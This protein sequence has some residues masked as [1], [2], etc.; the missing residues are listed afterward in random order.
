MRKVKAFIGLLIL[1]SVVYTI[2]TSSA[3][4]VALAGPSFES[5]W[6][7][8]VPENATFLNTTNPDTFINSDPTDERY[9][10]EG[11][12][13]FNVLVFADEEARPQNHWVGLKF[14]G[15]RD[16]IPVYKNWKQYALWQIERAD[17]TL[18]AE[19][20]IDIRVIDFIDTWDSKDSYEYMDNLVYELWWEQGHYL[21]GEYDGTMIDAIIGITAQ[22]TPGDEW[23]PGRKVYGVTIPSGT[24]VLKWEAYWADDNLVQ[25]EVSHLFEA[26]DVWDT[27]DWSIMSRD[28]SYRSHIVEDGYWFWIW[29][30]VVVAFLEND[31]DPYNYGIM[32]DNKDRYPLPLGDADFDADVDAADYWIWDEYYGTTHGPEWG[33]WN[34]DFLYDPDFDN[35]GIVTISDWSIWIQNCKVHALAITSVT[36]SDTRYGWTTV[37]AGWEVTVTVKVKNKG[38]FTEN[39]A[40]TAYYDSRAIDTQTVNNLAPGDTTTLTFIWDTADVYDEVH[41]VHHHSINYTISAEATVHPDEILKDD[42]TYTDGAIRVKIPGDLNDDGVVNGTD[43][44]AFG[45]DYPR[46]SCPPG[47]NADLDQDGDVD[48]TDFVILIGHYD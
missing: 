3:R 16:P 18:V 37:Y 14:G 34:D 47:I 31:Y 19:F 45:G 20:G 39:F 13:P 25:H 5:T 21:R 40:V 1:L 26:D 24:I 28:T 30:D 23:W 8:D 33:D 10:E 35:D 11:P 48:S 41:N 9:L 29:D 44:I 17:E 36:A 4:T 43:F 27:P 6:V 42:N 38:H 32:D 7:E 46:S 22:D 12:R 15:G 2:P